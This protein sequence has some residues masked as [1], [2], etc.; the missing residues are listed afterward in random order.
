MIPTLPRRGW[1]SA[2]FL[3]V[4][5]NS[6][7]SAGICEGAQESREA[8]RRSNPQSFQSTLRAIIGYWLR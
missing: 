1:R 2:P 3:A 5:P 8:H 6:L 4:I 7:T